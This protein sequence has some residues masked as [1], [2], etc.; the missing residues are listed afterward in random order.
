MCSTCRWQR[1]HTLVTH[2]IHSFIYPCHVTCL[3]GACWYFLGWFQILLK[4]EFTQRDFEF[5]GCD[6]ASKANREFPCKARLLHVT[7]DPH[8]CSSRLRKIHT[9][10][11]AWVQAA[12]SAA[13]GICRRKTFVFTTYSSWLLPMKPASEIPFISASLPTVPRQQPSASAGATGCD[14]HS[15]LL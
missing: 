12:W 9:A 2:R 14:F 4:Q 1:N 10:V 15:N 7:I 13:R 8:S 6:A 5:S 11:C 3:G